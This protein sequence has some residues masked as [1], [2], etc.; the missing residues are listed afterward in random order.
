MVTCDPILWEWSWAALSALLGWLP[1]RIWT[2]PGGPGAFIGASLGLLGASLTI[3]F[4]FKQ[5]ERRAEVERQEKK[6]DR[7]RERRGL[8]AA[9]QGELLYGRDIYWR[10]AQ[11]LERPIELLKQQP[12]DKPPVAP[13]VYFPPIDTPISAALIDRLGV[14]DPQI[15]SM[16]IQCRAMLARTVDRTF[17]RADEALQGHEDYFAIC[18]RTVRDLET[19]MENLEDISGIAVQPVVRVAGA[20]ER[21]RR[22]ASQ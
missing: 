16:I 13:Q 5:L 12:G 18:I 6:A 20:P 15:I 19:M 21:Q 11:R 17:T 4:G 9:L 7:E 8:A 3:Y 10:R 1:C 14:F 22:R 2:M